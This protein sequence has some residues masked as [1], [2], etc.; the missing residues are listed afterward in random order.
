MI[1]I[2]IRE[3]TENDGRAVLEIYRL[4]VQSGQATFETS[5]PAWN[6]WDK[7]YLEHSRFIAVTNN[8]IAGWVALSPVSAREVYKGVA[9]VS[10]YVDPAFHGKGVGS[11]LM[12]KVIESSET[13]GIWTL[14]SVVFP[15]NIATMKLHKKFGYRIIGTREKIARHNG[16]WRDTV[17]LERRSRLVGV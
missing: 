14:F 11:A 5:V 15:D 16:T 12:A 1:P 17:L 4:G 9:E 3:M 6:E 13:N 2:L 7:K 8:R 10:I